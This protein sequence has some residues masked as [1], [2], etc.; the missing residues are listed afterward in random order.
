MS[1]YQFNKLKKQFR[2]NPTVN[3]E[4]GRT[5]SKNGSIYNH[6]V[7]KYGQPIQQSPKKSQSVKSP[8]QSPRRRT[9]PFAVL[10]DESILRVLQKLSPENRKIWC[11]N[12]PRVNAICKQNNL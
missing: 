8:R 5:I 11:D 4:T 7:K 10:S 9:D 2:Q 3:P 6:L 12:S 1:T